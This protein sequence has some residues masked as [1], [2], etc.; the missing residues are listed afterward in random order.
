MYPATPGSPYTT[1]AVGIADDDTNITLTT[2][3]GF[4]AATNLAC[5]W[6][7]SGNFEVVKYTT[8]SGTTL[9]VERGFEGVAQ[10]WSAGAYI[11]NLIP[12]HAINSLQNNVNELNSSK[13]SAIDIHGTTEETTVADDDEILIYDT[14]ASANRR[15]TR[16]NFLDGISAVGAFTDLTDTP[17]SYEGYDET[18][19]VRVNAASN[20]L[21]FATVPSSYT[22]PVATDS[23]LGGIKIGSR[24]TITDGVLSADEQGD[25]LPS[26]TGNAGKFLTTDGSDVSW[27]D[28]LTATTFASG[29][30]VVTLPGTPSVGQI[31]EYVGTG[32]IWTINANTGQTIRVLGDTGNTLT[33]GHAYA[34]V[35]LVYI[36][37]NV[38]V[39]RSQVG[40]ASLTT[41]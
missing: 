17:A 31:F 4:A 30:A 39:L 35:G 37:D 25:S 29:D 16:A 3:P 11:A 36:D 6:D 18:Y 20:A 2:D 10:A 23:I 21:E 40:T 5:I 26:Q 22:L 13:L 12:A 8:L 7:D 1:L 33:A 41:V 32:Q 38:W 14:S 28:I 27:E 34:C 24:L 15:M 19:Y 9:T